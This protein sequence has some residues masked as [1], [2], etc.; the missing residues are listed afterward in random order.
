L[1][2]VLT[3][4][5]SEPGAERGHH[6]ELGLTALAVLALLLV[7]VSPV[8]V[9]AASAAACLLAAFFFALFEAALEHHSRARL[10]DVA[11]RLGRDGTLT[12]I[13]RREDELLF[14]T[15]FARSLTQIV[16]IAGGAVCMAQTDVR[17][18]TL[19]LGTLGLAAAFLV[20]NVALPHVVGRRAADGLL[21]RGLVAYDRGLWPL[22]APARWMRTFASWFAGGETP[23]DPNEEITDELLSVV[24]E[25]TREGTLDKSEKDMIQGIID[26][27]EGTAEEIMT[28]RTDLVAIPVG[29]SAKDAI[30]RSRERGLAR[31]PVYRDTPDEVVGV[32]YMKDLLPHWGRTDIPSVAHLMRRP[33]FVPRSKNIGDLLAEMKARRIHL[34]IV[35]DEYGGTAGI[36]SIEDIL[37]EIV[38]EITDEHEGAPTDVIRITE[39]AATVKARTPIDDLN[40]A[41]GLDVPE[42]EEYETVGGMLFTRMGRV[43]AAGETLDVNGARFTVLEADER[44]V[45][46]VKVT[47]LRPS[48]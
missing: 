11:A 30:E 26:L 3:E 31:L 2:P 8:A 42:S 18:L 39:N 22:R 4:S 32:L 37:E 38:G 10:M 27:R 15:K 43:P 21:L 48:A 9:L 12:E 19:V 7:A 16:G 17:G 5:D 28:P 35:L 36:V 1:E 6:P 23:A 40:D 13:L 24:E 25:G 14:E 29:A 20:L 34:A 33:F 47:V 46:R 45:N 41:L 44:Q